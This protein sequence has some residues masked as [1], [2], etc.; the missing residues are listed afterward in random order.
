MT[1]D[2]FPTSPTMDWHAKWIWP[3]P[4]EH[5]Q[6]R[7]SYA[8]FR[9]RFKG[10]G[11]AVLRIAADTEYD[12]FI[13][14][15]RISRNFIRS[16]KNYKR[17][18]DIS[19][20]LNPQEHILAVV[21]HHIGESCAVTQTSRPGL[22]LEIRN[23]ASLLVCT[24]ATWKTTICEAFQSDL[25]CRMSHF[26]FYK[27]CDYRKWPGKWL[28][29]DYDDSNWT[30]PYILGEAGCSP[31]KYL[32]PYKTSR[33]SGRRISPK[34]ILTGIFKTQENR[35][36]QATS[37]ADRMASR[38]R[39]TRKTDTAYPLTLSCT[40][41]NEF[42]VMDFGRTVSG[43]ISL[44]FDSVGEGQCI[45][46]GYDE[47]VSSEGYPDPRRTY[48]HYADRFVLER[49]QRKLEVSSSRGFRYLLIDIHKGRHGLVLTGA[50][51]LEDHCVLKNLT[52]FECADPFLTKLFSLSQ[53][54]LQSCMFDVFVDCPTRE[55]V[56]WMDYQLQGIF[57]AYGFNDTSLWRECLY[58]SAQNTVETGPLEG[59][60]KAFSP[61]DGN[62]VIP[63]YMML[64][65]IGV[66]EY[67]KYTGDIK[68][69]KQLYSTAKKQLHIMERYENN[70]GLFDEDKWTDGW[71]TFL[72]WSAMDTRGVCGGTNALYI[73]MH[74]KMVS[75]SRILNQES[76]ARR[77]YRKLRK[78]RSVFYDRF[79]IPDKKIF[80]DSFH[81]ENR[82]S[83]FSQLTNVFAL[84]AG[85]L[86]NKQARQLVKRIINPDR[87]LPRT[88]ADYR[89]RE[90]FIPDTGGIVPVGSGAA[91]GIMVMELFR[92]GFIREALQY[93]RKE[94]PLLVHN[95]TLGEVFSY[96][97]N[98][99][100]CHG[101]SAAPA[102]LLPKYT[103]GL[104]ICRPGWKS[105]IINPMP[106]DIL[107]AR[108][109]FPTVCGEIQ[110]SWKQEK[111]KMAIDLHVPN[112]I[113]IIN[114]S[115]MMKSKQ[116][117]VIISK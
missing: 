12:L 79:W 114:R 22:L 78:L 83:C 3:K 87:L 67:V 31:W 43:Y 95:G 98:S 36:V 59:A 110:I 9:K 7:N 64:Y 84:R 81:D 117:R 55:R 52:R 16:V 44:Y 26:G 107:W 29:Y 85:V 57:A 19:L 37:I 50:D 80:A 46:L 74:R 88:P 47:I 61:C 100:Y 33:H 32:L 109:T 8:L 23:D 71:G 94:W 97:K 90:D 106:G 70:K 40:N 89:L 27:V 51:I 68:T 56:A 99:S 104:H 34:P 92:L 39:T 72:D 14:G 112:S 30:S 6:D 103:L 113:K 86:R 10:G 53:N 76:M 102:M 13:D 17:Y 2:L 35:T 38:K 48:A 11:D 45:D 41:H 42:V 62:P 25:P 15:R 1:K 96:D 24:D 20:H 115:Q 54:T 63:S 91:A 77:F 58:L 82:G 101:W 105:I 49:G 21:V 69:A 93:L 65:V 60:V 66:T 73:L 5:A 75:L 108:G 116:H 18:E 111:E 28:L 4:P